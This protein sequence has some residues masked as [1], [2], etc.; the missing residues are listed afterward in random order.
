MEA[1]TINGIEYEG[2]DGITSRRADFFTFLAHV[3]G[4]GA[5]PAT[6]LAP[7]L[8]TTFQIGSHNGVSNAYAN[9]ANLSTYNN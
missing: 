3:N 1:I 6:T 7:V 5:G 8:G 9:F 2:Q 4:C